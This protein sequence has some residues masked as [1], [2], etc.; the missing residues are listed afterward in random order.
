M[1][2]RKIIQE[3]VNIHRDR[4]SHTHSQTDTCRRREGGRERKKQSRSPALGCLEKMECVLPLQ[5]HSEHSEQPLTPVGDSMFFS[6]S[7]PQ[8]DELSSMR[9]IQYG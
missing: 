4:T 2:K 1:L 9:Y 7:R 8:I 5:P 6:L 3:Q